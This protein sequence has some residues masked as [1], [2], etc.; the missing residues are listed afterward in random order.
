M[1]Q[2]PAYVQMITVVVAA[3]LLGHGKGQAPVTYSSYQSWQLGRHTCSTAPAA[4]SPQCNSA[5]DSAHH[6][7]SP[8]LQLCPLMCHAAKAPSQPGKAAIRPPWTCQ[9]TS[10]TGTEPGPHHCSSGDDGLQPCMGGGLGLSGSLWGPAAGLGGGHIHRVC[11][12]G[13]GPSCP[14]AP[15]ASERRGGALTLCRRSLLHTR[16]T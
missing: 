11:L 12:P 10:S 14:G 5:I 8:V 13:G 16:N 4:Q 1:D 15:G 6:S 3:W 9:H 7:W 2:D